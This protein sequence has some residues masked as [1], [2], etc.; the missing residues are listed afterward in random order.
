M[1]EIW[2]LYVENYWSYHVRTKALT[3]FSLTFQLLTPK[4]TGIFFSPFC[5]NVWNLYVEYWS[6]C[7]R[8]KVWSIF[9]FDLDLFIPK[10]I[11]IF[12]SPSCIYVWNMKAL[13]CKLLKLSCQ[14]KSKVQSRPLDPKVYRYLFSHHSASMYEI[15]M[16]KTTQVIV[17]EPECWQS[18][19][20]T[21]D[22]KM[23]IYVSFIYHPVS[24]YKIWKVY[25]EN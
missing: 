14:N 24:M 3:K 6:F 13:R 4:F 25:V 20:L 11:G 19:V 22:P 2:K 18:S 9:S 7:V 21:F 17:S 10:C 23:Y 16:L 1:Y 12:L 15:S 5:I 8:T